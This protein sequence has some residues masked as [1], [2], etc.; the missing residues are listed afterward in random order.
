SDYNT[1]NPFAGAVAGRVVD[2]GGEPDIGAPPALTYVPDYM[3]DEARRYSAGLSEAERPADVGIVYLS[4]LAGGAM[5]AGNPREAVESWRQ[6]LA[7]EP[8][9]VGL[10]L[11]LARALFAVEPANGT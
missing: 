11:S 10:W 1:L 3:K 6:A 5:G 7:I 8:G 2:H 9:D 4:S